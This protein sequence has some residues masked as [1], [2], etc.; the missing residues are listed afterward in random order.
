M[1][2]GTRV[3]PLAEP[4][5]TIAQRIDEAAERDFVG[6][7]QELEALQAARPHAG[8]PGRPGRLRHGPGGIGK[9]RLLQAVA[10]GRDEGVD[11]VLLDCREIEPTA[12]GFTGALAGALGIAHPDPGIARVAERIGTGGRRTVLLLDTY[13]R[14]ALLDTWLRQ[15]FLPSMPEHVLTVIAGRDTPGAAW[16]AAPGWAGLARELH[17]EPLDQAESIE[18]L[19]GRGLSEREAARVNAFARGHPLALELAASALIAE[20]E[21]EIERGPP[22]AVI[23]QLLD[24]LLAGLPPRTLETLEAVST[25]RR[26]TEPV[27][28]SLLARPSVRQEFEALERLPFVERTS[29]GLIVHDVVRE[30]IA[31]DLRD[32]D[33]E[34]YARYRRRAWSYF[35]ARARTPAPERLWAVTAD[36]IYLIE[37]PVLRTAC[38]P[39]GGG[40]H[41][42]EPAVA[43]DAPAIREIVAAHEGPAAA[44]LLGRWWA[45]QPE[46]FYVA[47]GPDGNVAAILHLC[48]IGSID[49]E[50][51]ARD[52]VAR[53]W[54]AHLAADPPRAG[55][56]VL[57]MRRW[58]GRDSGE[59]LSPAVGAC[60]LDVKRTYMELRPRLS[61]LY[62][63]MGDPP[64]SRRSSFRS[65]SRRW[66]RRWTSPAPRSSRCGSTSAR[67]ASTAGC[68]AW[69]GRRSTPRRPRC[70]PAGGGRVRGAHRARGRGARPDRRGALES[71]H[72]RAPGDQREDR[73]APRLEHLLQARRPQPGPGRGRRRVA[74]ARG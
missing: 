59:M 43:A 66:A 72:R 4:S 58:L 39:P 9:S 2:F 1:I 56:R 25:S 38:F 28:R 32:R 52:P 24:A 41:A 49:P 30:T 54:A 40:E 42:V 22:P 36:L 47:R 20:P 45:L 70:P 19:R 69:W 64:R 63:V 31:A 57:T 46:D 68:A 48:E 29:E 62:S 17:L 73:R 37:N 35:E 15:V 60:W 71:R 6:R 51:A 10:D 13:E 67:A 65:A 44:E 5:H 12:T 74:G 21:L 8:R 27:L 3:E 18:L 7:R 61:R 11:A 50:L 23:R 34:L 26:V 14:F 16:L 33:P 53:A 55:D